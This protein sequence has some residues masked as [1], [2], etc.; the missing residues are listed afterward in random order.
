MDWTKG[1]EHNT[2][3]LLSL[4]KH[5]V[6]RTTLDNN[7]NTTEQHSVNEEWIFIFKKI[8]IDVR[9]KISIQAEVGPELL[10]AKRKFE[11]EQDLKTS[12]PNINVN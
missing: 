1:L 8:V 9:T 5:Q 11:Q 3:N 7:C 2:G 6:G 4:M 12:F 10:F